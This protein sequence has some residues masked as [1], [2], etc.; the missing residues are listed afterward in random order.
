VGYLYSNAVFS[1]AN[2]SS[3]V[4]IG[5]NNILAGAWLDSGAGWSLP[6]TLLFTHAFDGTNF[7]YLG[8]QT[9]HGGPQLLKINDATFFAN[10]ELVA[11][12]RYVRIR[13][14]DPQTGNVVLIIKKGDLV[15]GNLSAN[16]VLSV[17]G[18][19]E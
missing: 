17:T 16:V 18:C 4:D 7:F 10:T 5:E 3:I 2:V 6:D 9:P 13:A 19:P 8:I 11:G 14:A 1:G 12:I 15:A